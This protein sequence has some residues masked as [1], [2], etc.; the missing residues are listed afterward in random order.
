MSVAK[1]RPSFPYNYGKWH[2]EA[3]RNSFPNRSSSC[4]HAGC[5]A[6]CTFKQPVSVLCRKWT[7]RFVHRRRSNVDHWTWTT[8]RRNED[9]YNT[10]V[11]RSFQLAS[12]LI[13][14]GVLPSCVVLHH[15]AWHRVW[16]CHAVAH[17]NAADTQCSVK[18]HVLYFQLC[19]WSLSSRCR[20]RL[21][22][23][24][25][26]NDLDVSVT[27]LGAFRVTVRIPM[28]LSISG[29]TCNL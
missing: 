5:G 21:V 23:S 29:V 22:F 9:S 4:Y 27:L 20:P 13:H 12:R 7:R 18:I 8:T 2:L 25:N 11:P 1:S 6:V 15:V 26:R 17:T 24:Q 10:T 14:S 28:L 16:S 3:L 19:L